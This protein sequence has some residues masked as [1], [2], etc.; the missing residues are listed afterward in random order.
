MLTDRCVCLLVSVAQG[1]GETS[2]QATSAHLKAVPQGGV[3]LLWEPL[4]GSW[5][6]LGGGDS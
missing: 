3:R 5:P 6:D 4:G 1:Q 2:V